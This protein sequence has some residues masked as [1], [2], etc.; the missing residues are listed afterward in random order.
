MYNKFVPQ[1]GINLFPYIK[2]YQLD[3]SKEY[4]FFTQLLKCSTPLKMQAILVL[5]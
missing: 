5:F 2:Y 1:T 4:G 3:P